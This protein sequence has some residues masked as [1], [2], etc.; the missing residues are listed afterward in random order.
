LPDFEYDRHKSFRKWLHTV[1]LNQWRNT[2]KRRGRQSLAGQPEALDALVAPDEFTAATEDEY[3]RYVVGR[4][5]QLMQA[6]F[7]ATTWQAC[8]EFVVRG[9][10]AAEVAR[11]LGVTVNAVYIAK[12]RV[13]ARLRQELAG[14]MD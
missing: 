9:R 11:E 3:R 7:Q 5:L 12:W 13:Q 4:A 1:A 10:P 6:K 14:L 8:W 2:R